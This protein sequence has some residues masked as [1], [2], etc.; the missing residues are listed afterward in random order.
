MIVRSGSI[1][2]SPKASPG[3]KGDGEAGPTIGGAKGSMGST[4][5]AWA[6]AGGVAL[7]ARVAPAMKASATSVRAASRAH[8][9][10]ILR[11]L[12]R[13]GDSPVIGILAWFIVAYGQSVL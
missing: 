9:I 1:T 5:F 13:S 11:L 10:A 3:C 4:G 6:S 2:G 7:C 12:R 8:D